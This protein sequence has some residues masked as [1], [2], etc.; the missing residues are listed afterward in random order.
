MAKH[1]SD[2]DIQQY[3][4]NKTDCSMDIV[5]HIHE[6]GYCKTKAD[7]Y[8]FLF[9]GIKQQ[10]K[11]GFDFDLSGLVIK[12]IPLAKPVF[13]WNSF[14]GYCII[15]LVIVVFGI[16]AY[17]YRIYISYLFKKYILS[18]ASGLSPVVF[19][20]LITTVLIILIFQ[21]IEMYKKYQKKIDTLNFY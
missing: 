11:P 13:S 2:I 5:E 8:L 15:G 10:P 16:P 19:F 6:C 3:V 20:L 7:E 17:L 12:Q 1:L 14:M 4:F 18:I 21:G 9:S